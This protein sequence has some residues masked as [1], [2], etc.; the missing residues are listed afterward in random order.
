M[1]AVNYNEL[2]TNLKLII[3]S[4]CINHEPVIVTRKNNKNFVLLSHEDYSAIEET[5]YL[6]KN[7]TNAKRLRESVK[8]FYEGKGEEKQLIEVD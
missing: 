1:Q 7:P 8:S 5:A 6:L 2:Q 4:V 3:D